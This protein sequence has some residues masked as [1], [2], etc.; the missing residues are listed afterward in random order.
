Q[1]PLARL[2]RELGEELERGRAARVLGERAAAEVA[3][4]LALAERIEEQSRA[5]GER[6]GARRAA[7]HARGAIPRLRPL[8]PAAPRRDGGGAEGGGAARVRAAVLGPRDQRLAE[9]AQRELGVAQLREPELPDLAQERRALV[10]RHLERELELRDLERDVPVR[11][12][13]VELAQRGE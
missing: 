2:R 10:R 1:R 6:V 8:R 9:V 11:A 5:R 13:G 12:R 3:R 7:Q 4:A